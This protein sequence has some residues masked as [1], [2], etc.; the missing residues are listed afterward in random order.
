MTTSDLIGDAPLVR[1][2]GVAASAGPIPHD[3]IGFYGQISG[4]RQD[5]PWTDKRAA[6]NR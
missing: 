4:M 3:K 5:R 6:V 2:A 1:A